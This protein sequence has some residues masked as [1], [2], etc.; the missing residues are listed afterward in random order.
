MPNGGLLRRPTKSEVAAM[1]LNPIGTSIG[2]SKVIEFHTNMTVGL[3][4]YP[5]PIADR[6]SFISWSSARSV[7]AIAQVANAVESEREALAQK[8]A[9]EVTL[10]LRAG[11]QVIDDLSRELDIYRTKPEEYEE[12]WAK[13]KRVKLNAYGNEVY[14]LSF[15]AVG[16]YQTVYW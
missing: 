2:A 15:D 9:E 16:V 5:H 14:S 4:A 11:I 8:Y 10:L 6:A 3:A 1:L 13:N 12:A 7:L